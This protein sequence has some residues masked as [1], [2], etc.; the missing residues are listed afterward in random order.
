MYTLLI[1]L[2]LI[3]FNASLKFIFEIF[4]FPPDLDMIFLPRAITLW[5]EFWLC[6]LNYFMDCFSTIGSMYCRLQSSNNYH[7]KFPDEEQMGLDKGKTVFVYF[8]QYC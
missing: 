3:S 1:D 7:S 2:P 5:A 4:N 6:S 8:V